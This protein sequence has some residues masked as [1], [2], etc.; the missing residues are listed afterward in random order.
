VNF[1]TNWFK[2]DQ[3]SN[4]KFKH[5]EQSLE[6]LLSAGK[7]KCGTNCGCK[8]EKVEAPKPK[9]KPV[10]KVEPAKKPVAKKPAPKKPKAE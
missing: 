2:K 1:F 6:T 4:K 8:S 10:V 3:D 5:E 9:P 7:C